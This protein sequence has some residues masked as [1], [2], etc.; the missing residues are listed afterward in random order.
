M[1]NAAGKMQPVKVSVNLV[2]HNFNELTCPYAESP[3]S[4]KGK[5]IKK[6]SC[7]PPAWRRLVA[8]GQSPLGNLSALRARIA[9]RQS[10]QQGSQ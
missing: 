4:M 5:L 6:C 7:H 2:F 10:I 3:K 9:V 8:R 1:S